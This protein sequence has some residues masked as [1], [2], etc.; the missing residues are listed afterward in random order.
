MGGAARGLHDRVLRDRVALRGV[1]DADPVD[2]AVVLR[3]PDPPAACSDPVREAVRARRPEVLMR[4]RDRIEL[5]DGRDVVLRV[6][7]LPVRHREV[8]RTGPGRDGPL[9][10]ELTG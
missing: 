9:T 10:E 8:P 2:A 7:E 6:P 3:E 5:A 4:M 1:Q